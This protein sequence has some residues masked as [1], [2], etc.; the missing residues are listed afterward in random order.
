MFPGPSTK[1]WALTKMAKNKFIIPQIALL[2]IC[3]RARY[4]LGD[5]PQLSQIDIIGLRKVVLPFIYPFD[6]SAHCLA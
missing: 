4:E 2:G 6:A 1:R 5:P 3:H